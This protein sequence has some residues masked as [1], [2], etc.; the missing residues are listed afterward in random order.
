MSIGVRQPCAKEPTSDATPVLELEK[1]KWLPTPLLSRRLTRDC[2]ARRIRPS[3]HDLGLPHAV[4]LDELIERGR[5][6][7]SET[8]ATVGDRRTK[9]GMV[10]AMD[11][12]SSLSEENRMRHP[13]LSHSWE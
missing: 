10:R 11:A 1:S 12:V 9:A 13:A 2:D 3:D 7:Q 5:V 8:D 6:C 4:R